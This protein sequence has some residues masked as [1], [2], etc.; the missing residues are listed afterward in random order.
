[1]LVYLGLG[2]N[3]GNR[4]ETINNAVKLLSEQVG[5]LIKRSSFFYSKPLGFDSPNDFCNICAAFD[6]QLAPLDLLH[7]TQAIERTLGRTEKSQ[8]GIYH[9]RTID[10]DILLYEGVQMNTPELTIPHPEIKKRDFVTSP[11]KE[12]LPS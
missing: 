10:I 9:D 7:T 4:E 12:I 1:M 5:P 3:L 8:N 2:A 6:T 11:L